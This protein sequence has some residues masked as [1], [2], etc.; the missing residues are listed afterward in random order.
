MILADST[1][2]QRPRPPA[3]RIAL[4][5]ALC[6][7]T[8]GLLRVGERRA[9][10]LAPSTLESVGEDVLSA[11]LR[12]RFALFAQDL[13]TRCG[14]PEVTSP[15]AWEEAAVAEYERLD[16]DPAACHRLGIIYARRGYLRQGREMLTRAMTHDEGAAE[17][18]LAL[19][20][21]YSDTPIKPKDTGR[22][23]EE[24]LRQPRWLAMWTMAD[25]A[26]RIDMPQL[27]ANYEAQARRAIWRFGLAVSLLALTGVS[28]IGT[29]LIALLILVL[30]ALFDR[31]RYTAQ[32]FVVLPALPW[33]DVLDVAALAMFCNAL[34]Q[35]A[36]DSLAATFPA[37]SA[38]DIGLRAAH[39]VF[40]VLPPLILV[41]G[42]VRRG[43]T[44]WHRALGLVSKGMSRHLFQGLVGLGLTLAAVLVVRDMLI[45][46]LQAMLPGMIPGAVGARASSGPG[47]WSVAADLVLV[48]LLAPVA[49]EI[50]FR[51]F[52]FRALYDRVRPIAAAGLSAL[53]F[54][55]AHLAWEPQAFVSL[56]CLGM[57]SAYV[58]Q[59]SRS[60]IPSILLHAGY[61]GVILIAASVLRM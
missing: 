58:Y 20:V 32:W 31:H 38:A 18:Y 16:P 57:V 47:G 8:F 12:Y 59:G 28:I 24:L 10:P 42:R 26:R 41:I 4:I 19:L 5:A 2:V 22:L 33:V 21:V 17:A 51:G 55:A 60:L 9:P 54:A 39:A 48:L 34:G 56:F 27:A 6:G 44:K 37:G 61:N 36:R 25:M 7:A 1:R 35:V 23:R 43:P 40:A 50:I 14:V 15:T 45:A 52:L 30:R 49:E 29:S 3:L 13:A 46:W 53:L 11:D